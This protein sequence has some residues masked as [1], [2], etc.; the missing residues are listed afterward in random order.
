METSSPRPVRIA[1]FYGLTLATGVG[2]FFLIR[3]TGEG[4][5]P[6]TAESTATAKSGGA[7][8]DVL[9]HVLATLAAVI[10]LGHLLGRVFR[11]IGQPPVI[12]E[13]VAGLLLG[14]SFLGEI[15]PDMMH[16]LIP[17]PTDDPAGKVRGALQMI[18]QLGVILY[19]FLVGM[20]LNL[21]TLRREA[22][23]AVAISHSGILL[24][25]VLGS[26]LALGL[27]RDLAPAGVPFTSFALFMGVA[28]SITAFPVLAR[29]LTDLRMEKTPLGVIALGC[30]AMGDATAWCILAFVVGVAQ[31]RVGGAVFVTVGAL[32]FVTVMFILVRPLATKLAR[33]WETGPLP[34]ILLPSV[35]TAVILS[36]LATESIGIH[37]IFGAFLLGAVIP[38]ESRLAAECHRKLHD[39]VTI[40]MLPAFFAIT[41]MNTRVG[42]IQ[43]VDQWMWCGLII[44]VATAGKFGGTVLA[45][46]F[47][48]QNWKMASALGVLM[49]T[50]GLMELIVL[51]VGLELGIITPTLF[52]MMVLMALVTTM[53]TS[54]ILVWLVPTPKPAPVKA[55][56]P[57][58]V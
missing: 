52:A 21:G 35:L 8:L 38:S 29:I 41:G 50:R 20:E 40:L 45:A 22:K 14:P 30:A 5:Q 13:I 47:T 56:E 28:M 17:S 7:K 6:P 24:P 23:S 39:L 32:S 15:S 36:A 51:N 1:L 11:F 34:P 10:A 9:V 16:L 57:V 4:L 31:A 53:A 37:A 3:Q 46:R 25:F 43:G 18:A 55:T 44:L 54:P 33:R 48:G 49:N 19:M 58:A 26:A 27:F 12:G 2:L 42:L